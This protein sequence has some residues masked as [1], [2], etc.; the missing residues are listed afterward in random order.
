VSRPLLG[1]SC[2][3]HSGDEPMHGVI[4]RYIRAAALHADADIVLLPALGEMI[5]PQSLTARLDGVLLTGSPSNVEGWRYG[6][7]GAPGPHDKARDLSNFVLVEAMIAAGKAV[8]GIC[9]GLQEINVAF[10]GTLRDIEPDAGDG[11]ALFH[12]AR[13]DAPLDAVFAHGHEIVLT[14][15]GMLAKALDADRIRVNSV[16]YQAIDRLGEGLFVEAVSP[17]GVI[18]AISA[19]DGPAW[20]LGVQWHPEWDDAVNPVSAACFTMLGD[21]MRE[22]AD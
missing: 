2:C 14:G 16:H 22:F 12:R 18:E 11:R 10:G 15:G 3:L 4:D 1:V 21:A 8:L 7:P 6:Q 20:V 5:D 17:D 13:A 19:R 9:R